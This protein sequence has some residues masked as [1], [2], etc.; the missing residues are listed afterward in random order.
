MP[1]N[2][3]DIRHEPHLRTDGIQPKHDPAI[4][5]P[6]GFNTT[7]IQFSQHSED[8]IDHSVWDEPSLT[9]YVA[10]ATPESALTYANWLKSRRESWS[11]AS[12]WAVTLGVVM[13]AIPCAALAAIISWTSGN[14]FIASDI[15]VACIVAPM[16]QEICK[17]AVPLWIVEKRPY[18]FTTW[19]Q[20][21]VFAL[22]SAT[23]FAVIS[24]LILSMVVPEVTRSIFLFQWVGVL[25]VNLLTASIATHG[26]ETIW[27]KC[28]NSGKP[29]KLD[30]GYPYFATA[31]GIHVVFAICTTIVFLVGGFG[32][33]IPL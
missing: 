7:P 11:Q 24:N 14:I 16:L 18:F 9:P 33:L 21:F 13:A 30:H 19:F 4:D 5:A 2:D 15:L 17:I 31:I 8:D 1:S 20:F 28:I 29:P 10:A 6:L 12:A 22:A 27:R 23:V 26:L 3:P 25:G 32:R